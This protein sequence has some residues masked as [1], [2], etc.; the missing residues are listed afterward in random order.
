MKKGEIFMACNSENCICPYTECERHGKCCDCINH[1][2]KDG[3]LVNCLKSMLE[4]Q[5]K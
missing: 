5:S 2:R 3:S 4:E 1:H